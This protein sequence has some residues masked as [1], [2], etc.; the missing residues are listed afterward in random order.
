MKKKI[1]LVLLFILVAAG[2]SLRAYAEELNIPVKEYTLSNGIKVLIVERHTSPTFSAQIL[3]KTGSADDPLGLTGVAHM[4]E[5]M[6]FKGTKTIGT[7]NYAAEAPIMKKIDILADKIEKEKAK[8]IVDP[9]RVST[10]K[11]RKM[12]DEIKSLESGQEKYAISKEVASIYSKNGG[13]GFN[14][15]TNFDVTAYQIALPSNKLE[16]WAYMESDRIENPVFR[17]FFAERSTVREERRLRL[18]DDP[19]DMGIIAELLQGMYQAS[20]YRNFVIGWPADIENFKPQD[21][22]DVFKRNYSPQNM[23]I[24]IVGDVNP[25]ETVKI[26]KKYFGG[27]KNY[28]NIRTVFTEEVPQKGQRRVEIKFDANPKILIGFHGPKP[29]DKDRF[30]M[31]LLSDILSFGTTSR[32]YKQLVEN[33]NLVSSISF[34]TLVLK[35]E[36]PIIISAEPVKGADIRVVEKEIFNEIEKIKNEKI[37]Q[38]ELEKAKNKAIANFIRSLEDPDDLAYELANSEGLYG[39]WHYFDLRK[40]YEKITADDIQKAARK[41]LNKDNST[42]VELVSNK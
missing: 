6:M 5:H 13:V 42:V 37:S 12:E 18:E 38:W 20:P 7:T 26:I 34:N 31:D 28:G 29:L 8:G 39:S 30:A 35:R 4:L 11:I 15:G 21:I 24:A 33:K 10:E 22:M 40:E 36:V 9:T 25:D 17:M 27:L 32:L 23:V 2:F 19:S 3:F 41:Y 14:A 16:L 1:F